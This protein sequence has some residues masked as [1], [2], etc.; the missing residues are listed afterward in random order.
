MPSTRTTAQTQESIDSLMK[1]DK[2]KELI[3]K[4]VSD[5]VAEKTSELSEK[6]DECLG[7][8]LDLESNLERKESEIVR[9]KAALRVEGDASSL[10]KAR[11]EDQEQYSRRNNIRV[12]GIEEKRGENTDQEIINLAERL[13]LGLT[14]SDIDRSH[15]TGRPNPTNQQTHGGMKDGKLR[16]RPIL[17]KFT[18][19]RQRHAMISRRKQ[20]KKTGVSISEDLSKF[21][22]NLLHSAG[23]HPAVDQAWAG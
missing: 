20:L 18:S 3:N 7:R 8:I 6:I 9:L 10:L 16:P 17:V 22:L 1:S 14:T 21:K 15:R 23:K 4:T 12:F 2:F 5:I 19:Y 11:C 13:G